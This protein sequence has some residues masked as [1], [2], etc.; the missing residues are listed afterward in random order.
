MAGEIRR[1]EGS[2]RAAKSACNKSL[3]DDP[4]RSRRHCGLSRDRTWLAKPDQR[5]ARARRASPETDRLTAFSSKRRASD[6]ARGSMAGM[7]RRG[8]TFRY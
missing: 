7:S 2:T 4:S 1:G 6:R 3:D 5:N 8:F